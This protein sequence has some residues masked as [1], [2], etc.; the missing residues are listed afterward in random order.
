MTEQDFKEYLKKHRIYIIGIRG[1]SRVT[2]P[3]S[4]SIND[5]W[6]KL[7]KECFDEMFAKGWDGTVYQ[8]KEKYGG[9]RVYIKDSAYDDIILKYERQSLE[10]CER[11]GSDH[12]ELYNHGGWL[13]TLCADCRQLLIDAKNKRT[14]QLSSKDSTTIESSSAS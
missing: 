3:L 11:C 6:Y 14:E 4:F 5:G 13:T 1:K 8:I 2:S 7:L 12:A 10:T 9:L